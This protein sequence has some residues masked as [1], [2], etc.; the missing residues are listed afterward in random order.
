MTFLTVVP[1]SLSE[2]D[3]YII[4]YMLAIK[5]MCFGGVQ[6]II[7]RSGGRGNLPERKSLTPDYFAGAARSRAHSS[8]TFCFTLATYA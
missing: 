3:V 8:A 6:M 2:Y 4:P 7:A 1:Y 5:W